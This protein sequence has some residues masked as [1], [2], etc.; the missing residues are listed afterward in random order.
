MPVL[1]AVT[2]SDRSVQRI[3]VPVD[4]WLHGARHHVVQ[5]AGHP[6]V[7]RVEIDPDGDFPDVNR[8]NQRWTQG[9]R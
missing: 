6:D 8:D 9:G 3:T 1:L 4:V 7:V 2:R 5:V